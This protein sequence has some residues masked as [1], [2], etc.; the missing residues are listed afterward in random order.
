M[1]VS[2]DGTGNHFGS[3][4]QKHCPA[5]LA[6]R[7]SLKR[8]AERQRCDGALALRHSAAA[9]AHASI[10][11][12]FRPTNLMKG[13]LSPA[14]WP[15]PSSLSVNAAFTR[16]KSAI[17]GVRVSNVNDDEVHCKRCVD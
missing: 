14:P 10:A 5:K 11:E 13:P 4:R 2:T 15:L 17:G 8:V 16:G 12:K 7:G 9:I 6:L 3:T 1:S